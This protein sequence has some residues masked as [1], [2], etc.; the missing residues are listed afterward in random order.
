MLYNARLCYI[1]ASCYHS[2]SLKYMFYNFF[3]HGDDGVNVV[4]VLIDC[5]GETLELCPRV[6]AIATRHLTQTHGSLRSST[7]SSQITKT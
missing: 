3:T 7:N 2:A 5:H 4:V 6:V 1:S